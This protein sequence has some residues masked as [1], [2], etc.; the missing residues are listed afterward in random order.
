MVSFF[1]CAVHVT[2]EPVPPSYRAILERAWACRG[3]TLTWH[4]SQGFVAGVESGD[5]GPV[6][7][8]A[9]L[10][11]AIAVGTARLDNRATL[12]DWCPPAGRPTGDLEL[13]MRFVLSG[14]G[15]SL[16]RLIGDFA[17]VV[18]DPTTRRLV[19]ARD[20]FGVRKLYYAD[21]RDA[22][23]TFCSHA[24][25]LASGDQYDVQYLLDRIAYC[26]SGPQRTVYG[27]VRA[28]PPAGIVGLWNGTPR[29]TTYW[30]AGEAQQRRVAL[31]SPTDQCDA[32]RALLVEGVRARLGDPSHTWSHL[33]GGLDSSSVV[34][35]AQW[36]ARSGDIANGLA[37]TVTYTDSLGT[38]ADEKEYSDAVVQ[39]YGIRNELVPHRAGR[40]EALADPPCLDQPNRSYAAA[41]RDL[42]AGRVVRLHGGRA[43]LT[44]L[45]GDNLVLGTMFFF[46]DWI[47]TGRVWPAVREMARRA[48]MGRVSF[49]QLAYQ[50]AVLPLMPAPVRRMLARAESGIPDWVGRDAAR[51]FDLASHTARGRV[52]D[53]RPGHLYA[54]AVLAA[55]EAIPSTLIQGPLEEVLDVQHPFLHRPLVELA[56]QLPAE[57]C[58]RPFQRKWILREAMRGILPEP[59][60]R[61]VGKGEADGL[62]CWSLTHES[63]YVELLLKDPILAQLGCIDLPTFRRALAAAGQGHAPD[64]ISSNRI[65]NVLDVEMWL[66]LRSGRWAAESSQIGTA[67]QCTGT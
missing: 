56:L 67:R 32:F 48:A 41:L 6:V 10:G 12:V 53:G 61:R 39:E 15:D 45:G 21:P 60:R 46:A 1:A 26:S 14:S 62:E 36:L 51:R 52:Y 35:V 20:V 13:A 47:A 18:W 5:D 40:M 9:R 8:V 23:V 57:M 4:R 28:V 50:N 31:G 29:V 49:W 16:A 54:G 22:L 58:V 25:P 37:G 34:S 42:S 65:G 38:G 11:S 7:E 19:A 64:G 59:V 63:K 44:G 43:L 17:F 30:S 3:R 2:A 66:Q 33:S 24:E 55:V 27:G